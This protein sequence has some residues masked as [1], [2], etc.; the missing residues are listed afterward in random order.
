MK[1]NTF[2]LSLWRKGIKSVI[3]Q[4]YTDQRYVPSSEKL[5]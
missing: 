3:K 5:D 1:Y 4:A 2:K